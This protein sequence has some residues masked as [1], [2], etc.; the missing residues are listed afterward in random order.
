MTRISLMLLLGAAPHS[1]AWSVSESE[2][3]ILY[4]SWRCTAHDGS[5]SQNG[6]TIDASLPC[7]W[8]LT[9]AP[10][11][12]SLT[13]TSCAAAKMLAAIEKQELSRS[14]LQVVVVRHAEDISWS[15]PFAAV[16]TVYEKPG[17]ELAALSPT[18]PLSATAAASDAASVVL[19]NVGKE[20][21]AYLTHIV[22]NY[23]SLADRTVFMH[24]H[25]PTCGFFLV[26]RNHVGNHLLTNVSVLDY[27]QSE[28][29]LYMPLTGRANHDLT[30]ASVRST[31]ADGLSSRPRVPRPVPAYPIYKPDQK[32]KAEEGGGDRWLK[33]EAND[34]SRHAKELTL[35]QG[36]LS[37]VEMIDFGTFFQRVVGRAPPA[38]LYFAHGAQFAASRA[39]LRST[40]KET[41]EWILE[42]V[43]AGHFEV[44]FY[45]EMSW[46]YVLHG[47]AETNWEAAAVDL[48]K[49]APY[50][51]HLARARDMFEADSLRRSLAASPVPEVSPPPPPPPTVSPNT[52]NL[53]GNK[54]GFSDFEDSVIAM[55]VV[56]GLM[57]ACA[58]AMGCVYLRSLKKHLPRPLV[59]PVSGV[60]STT[61]TIPSQR[62]RQVRID[63][64]APKD[65]TAA[66][67]TSTT[68]DPEGPG[69]IAQPP[70]PH[71][72][73]LPPPASLPG[74]P[75][76]STSDSM[77]GS[78]SI[79][80]AER[81]ERARAEK[82]GQ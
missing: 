49:A 68:T 79:K 58:C 51:D 53:D 25:A 74:S 76:A 82:R 2:D 15:D 7:S 77:P 21:H 34:L 71:A 23:D 54:D 47:A 10:L 11:P 18:T 80:R 65:P 81:L 52:D 41:Y 70:M 12:E 27:L 59:C 40:S 28:G 35:N 1:T 36:E 26:D 29:D 19:P 67:T 64:S 73:P 75:S 9:D 20:Q 46:L 4:S 13:S 17:T 63:P 48:D 31:F 39:A 22:R 38:V 66:I 43:E 62:T 57:V 5:V 30:L 32:S 69:P 8:G 37:A 3:A 50:L 72:A 56:A 14:E 42:L 55:F 24:G 78:I 60:T 33:W 61:R 45:L 44:T 6:V 16:R